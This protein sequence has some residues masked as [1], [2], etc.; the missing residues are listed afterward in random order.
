MQIRDT[1]MPADYF[2][3][4]ISFKQQAVREDENDILA[5]PAQFVRLDSVAVSLLFYRRNLWMAKYSRGYPL[6]ELRNDFP[7]IVKDWEYLRQVDTTDRFPNSLKDSLDNYVTSLWLLSQA[8]LVRVE[9][10]VFLRLLACI[11]HEGQDLLFERLVAA[12][13]PGIG[14]KPAEQLLYPKA[15]QPLYEALDAA[16]AAQPALLRQFLKHWYKR[17]SKAGWHDGHKGPKGGG[18][19]GYWCWEAAGVAGAFGIDDSSFRDM[20]YYPKDLADFAR[21]NLSRI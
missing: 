2:D 17:M 14:R 13:V 18:Y 4:S 1:L 19:F 16:P 6:E 8:H 20:P 15:Y 12:I 9:Q 11:G 7:A 10:S 3:R 21:V 5:S